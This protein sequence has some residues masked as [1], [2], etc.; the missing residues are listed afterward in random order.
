MVLSH[1][2]SGELIYMRFINFGTSE[3]IKQVINGMD[4]NDNV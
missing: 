3:E 1:M 4:T 2:L